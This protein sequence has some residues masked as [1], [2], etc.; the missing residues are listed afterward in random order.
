MKTDRGVLVRA[1][2]F[3][4]FP[5][6]D[7]LQTLQ[8]VSANMCTVWNEG[9]AARDTIFQEHYAPLYAELKDTQSD[10]EKKEIKRRLTAAFKSHAITAFDQINNL[11]SRRAGDQ[12]FASVPRNW[13]EQTLVMLHGATVSFL[14]LRKNGDKDARPPRARFDTRFSE[15]YGRTGFKIEDEGVRKVFIMRPGSVGVPMRFSIPEYECSVLKDRESKSGFAVK[16]FTLCRNPRNLSKPGKFWVSVMYEYDL[17]EEKPDVPADRVYIAVGASSL[18]V[19]SAQGEQVIELWRPDKHWKPKIEKVQAR[20]QPLTKGSRKWNGLANA[21]R[22]MFG[23]LA[24]QQKQYHA[25]VVQ[26]L[27]KLGMH[28]VI[29]DLVVRSKQGKLADSNVEGRSG[30]LGLNWAAQ[31]TGNIAAFVA[32][33][34]VKVPEHG[35]SVTKHKLPFGDV[36]RHQGIG[37]YNKSAMVKALKSSFLREQKKP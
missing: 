23:I 2:K 12:K 7:N 25:E 14:V 18:G 27:L 21:R 34:K 4:I 6:G 24:K 15:I 28:F 16:Q 35:G 8:A 9:F 17:P 3:E 1:I 26:K 11:T 30:S 22:K 36:P 5:Q 33:L 31:N 32:Q 29:S 20:M 10:G 19:I 37:H 13:Q